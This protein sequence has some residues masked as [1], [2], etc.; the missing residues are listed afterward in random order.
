MKIGVYRDLAVG[1]NG[2]GPE[3]WAD[4]ELYTPRASIGAPPVSAA[5][6]SFQ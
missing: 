6:V 4:R 1:V 2:S 5:A 3:A